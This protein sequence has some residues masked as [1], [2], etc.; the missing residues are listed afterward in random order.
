MTIADIAG[1]SAIV[2]SSSDS[3]PTEGPIKK[4]RFLRRTDHLSVKAM[5][6]SA[7]SPAWDCPL[8]ELWNVVES[9]DK[10]TQFYS[11]LVDN[12]PYR[13]GIAI[14]RLCETLSLLDEWL[15]SSHFPI[16][17]KEE[18][19]TMVRKEY[20]EK[21]KPYIA[22]LNGG[23]ASQNKKSGLFGAGGVK[24]NTIPEPEVEK[25]VEGLYG[26]LT[27][28]KS[29]LRSLLFVVSWGAVPWCAYVGEKVVRSAICRTGGKLSKSDLIAASKARLCGPARPDVDDM[30][31]SAYNLADLCKST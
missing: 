27:D 23:K 13:R 9:G 22:I 8:E 11:E 21:L 2:S 30:H 14:S 5:D 3:P 17:F 16:L 6:P 24:K 12:D 7:R 1:L 20:T 15:S 4:R 10:W 25:A 26:W 31:K 28:E 18:V 29:L 19:V